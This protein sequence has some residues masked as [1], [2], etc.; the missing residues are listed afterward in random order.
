MI[1]TLALVAVLFCLSGAAAVAAPVLKAEVI[2]TGEIVTVGD[3]FEDAGDLATRP[4][5]RAPL[6]GTTGIVSLEALRQAAGAAGLGTFETEGVVR[7]RVARDATA[8]DETMLIALINADLA[9]R[10]IASTGVSAVT[11]LDQAGFSLNA[12]ATEKPATLAS[13]RYMPGSGAFSARFIIAGHDK[14]IDVTGRIDLMVEAPHLVNSMRAGAVLRESDIEMKLVPLKY[15]ETSGFARKD[16]LIG[17]ALLR[18][19]RAG[20]MLRASDV[21][22]PELVSRNDIVTVYFRSGPLTL[23]VK[24]QALGG[25][26]AGEPVA[27]INL[28]SRKVLTGVAIAEGAVE[29]VGSPMTV[30]GL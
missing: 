22:E 9:R 24:G 29:I 1:R 6:P 30:A 14:P 13:L 25:A 20:M 4:L 3:M 15:A 27:V 17:K 18:Q 12:E 10:G 7:V 26:A 11:T 28:M 8:V 2:V 5:F 23:T 21:G 19:S 16:E